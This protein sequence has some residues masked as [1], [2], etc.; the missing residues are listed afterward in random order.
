MKIVRKGYSHAKWYS[1]NHK[2][3]IPQGIRRK[4]KKITSAPNIEQSVYALRKDEL[5]RAREIPLGDAGSRGTFFVGRWSYYGS[6]IFSGFHEN[7]VLS[8]HRGILFDLS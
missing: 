3:I 2:K 6:S 7:D 5:G 4:L 1:K 8:V